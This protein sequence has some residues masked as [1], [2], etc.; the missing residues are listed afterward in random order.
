MST[1]VTRAPALLLLAL[2][3]AAA[4]GGSTLAQVPSHLDI[5]SAAIEELP[6][7]DPA[8]V[9]GRSVTLRLEV[10]GTPVCGPG[11]GF[12]AYG[13]LIDTDSDPATGVSLPAFAGLGV[14]AR[15]SATCDPAASVFVSPV[16]AVSLAP[17]SAGT[18]A[19]TIRTTVAQL[20][21]LDFRWIAFAQ[22]GSTFSRLPQAPAYSAWTTHEK[23]VH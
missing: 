23:G 5:L 20:P 21:A 9:P 22:E 14:E 18:T 11:T 17:G 1:I 15:V 6:P 8:S 2:L 4:A 10:N 12:L 7:I 16:G 13:V 3:G 19:I